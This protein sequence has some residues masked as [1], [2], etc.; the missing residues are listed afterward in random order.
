MLFGG[1][2]TITKLTLLSD[3]PVIVPPIYKSMVNW[4]TVFICSQRDTFALSP[5]LCITDPR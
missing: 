4:H 5:V 3:V 2:F 1:I